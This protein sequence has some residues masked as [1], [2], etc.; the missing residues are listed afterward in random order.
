MPFML[1]SYVAIYRQKLRLY[2]V[3]NM[4]THNT[5]NSIVNVKVQSNIQALAET[6][7]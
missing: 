2:L 3:K 7:T 6:M 1:C 5:H 4:H